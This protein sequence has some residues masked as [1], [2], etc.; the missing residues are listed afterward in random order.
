[1]H[2]DLLYTATP[3]KPGQAMIGWNVSPDHELL[4]LWTASTWPGAQTSALEL[5]I[6][7]FDTR[8]RTRTF[9]T[10]PE[11]VARVLRQMTWSPYLI[12]KLQGNRFLLG[13][14][15]YQ[16]NGIPSALIVDLDQPDT[17]TTGSMGQG[18]DRVLT[19][20]RDRI[21]TT[22]LDEGTQ[23][24]EL[25]P[26]QPSHANNG[27]LA[28][29]TEFTVAWQPPVVSMFMNGLNIDDDATWVASYPR[30][31]LEILKVNDEATHRYIGPY[32]MGG[33]QGLLVDGPRLMLVDYDRTKGSAVLGGH[34]EG[35]A[36]V[37]DGRMPFT[38]EDGSP[39]AHRPITRGAHAYY[40]RTDPR[41]YTGKPDQPLDWYTY[42]FPR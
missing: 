4:E 32:A 34:L 24:R 1:M 9:V 33:V 6:A 7:V 2:S 3:P 23:V 37:I 40:V 12:Q 28:W 26:P 41:S 16:D 19:D 15:V 5:T 14:G 27:V 30:N 18:F 31:H 29:T 36:M 11:T 17:L 39:D 38:R 20:R 22:Y 8:H 35:N 42:T 21:W 10:V 13:T 25:P